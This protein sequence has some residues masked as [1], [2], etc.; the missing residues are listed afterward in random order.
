MLWDVVL[1]RKIS[2]RC[3]HQRNMVSSLTSS[4]LITESL[5]KK[6]LVLCF[7]SGSR[8]LEITSSYLDVRSQII[9][10]SCSSEVMQHGLGTPLTV[11]QQKV[12][13]HMT[14]AQYSTWCFQTGSPIPLYICTIQ[15][16]THTNTCTST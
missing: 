6:Y 9:A 13:V 14:S 7:S 3:I 16:Y 12:F 8:D 2:S 15:Q 1:T 5:Y 10:I 4:V 11:D